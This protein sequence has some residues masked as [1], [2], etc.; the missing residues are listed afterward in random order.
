MTVNYIFKTAPYGHQRI[1]LDKA[2]TRDRYGFLMEMGT[3]KSKCLIDN[4][5]FLFEDGRVNFALIIAPKG[6]YRNWVSKEIPEHLPDRVP[7]RVIRWA[8]SPTVAQKKEMAAVKE[9]FSGLTI[10]VMNVESFSTPKGQQAG[11]WFAKTFG[12]YGLI[13]IDESTTIKNHEAKR[14]KAL[15]KIAAG[16]AFRRILTGS[17]VT[18]SP[19]DV[20]SQFE[21]LGPG[22]LGFDSFYA[23]QARY[24]VLQKRKMGK[25]SF[26]QVVG[27]RN[28]EE[29]TDR[30]DRFSYRVLKKDCLDLPEKIYTARYVSLTDEQFQMYEQIRT[31][32]FTM[33]KNGEL[34]TAQHVITQLL[35]LQQVMSGHLRTDEGNLVTFKSSRM[36]ALLEV[37]EEHDGNAIIWSRFRHDIQEITK[38]LQRK[39]GEHTTAA[40]Y[41]DTSSDERNRIVR[42]FQDRNHPLRY[43]V[44]NPSTGGYGL[45]LTEANLM[46]FYANSFDL[47]HRLQAQDRIHRIGQRNP[48]TYVDLI[49]EGTIDEKIVQA[50]R[51]KIELGAKVLGE[52]AQAWL[53]LKPAKLI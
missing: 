51:N 42:D 33:L 53:S 10:F 35:R 6:V 38:A 7:H 46:V 27:Y 8:A 19:L 21:F 23:F 14:T 45:T 4:L 52:E 30:I 3:G 28:I 48:C 41:G 29:L 22:T 37:L 40:Y 31:T 26:N 15:T 1:A 12:K 50:L 24:A 5:A 36:D 34:V 32:A 25:A 17:P 9:P 44:G 39:Y 18:K 47:E 11:M 2:G 16:F 49:T 43:F 20:Y 13:G